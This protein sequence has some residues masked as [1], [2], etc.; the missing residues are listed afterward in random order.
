MDTDFF[1]KNIIY[2][3]HVLCIFVKIQ[4]L[5]GNAAM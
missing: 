1:A 2:M 4:C 3:M 5:S